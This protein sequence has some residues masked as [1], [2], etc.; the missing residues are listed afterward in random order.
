M[1]RVILLKVED[2]RGQGK[3]I[4][5]KGTAQAKSRSGERACGRQGAACWAAFFLVLQRHLWHQLERW[6]GPGHSVPDRSWNAR[7]LKVFCVGSREVSAG[8][9][10]Q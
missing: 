1:T 7:N 10:G 2:G 5:G 9:I 3:G 8:E 4:L 6:A